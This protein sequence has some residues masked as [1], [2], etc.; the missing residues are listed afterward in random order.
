MNLIRV[1]LVGFGN[2][3]RALV[4]L[5]E[6]KQ[7]QLRSEFGFTTL[8]TG[9][10]TGHHGMAINI[11]GIDIEQ[12]LKISHDGQDISALSAVPDLSSI[13][14]FIN[15]V[16]ADVLFENSPVNHLTGQPAADHLR[17][18]LERGMH[19]ITANKGPVVHAYEE[20]SQLAKRKQ[21]RFLFES[22]VMDGAPI[23][24]LFRGP[25][26][27]VEL[28]GFQGI[29]NSCTNL[30][31][32]MMEGGR[33]FEEA[34]DYGRSIGITETDPSADI[35]GWDAAIKVA[36]LATVLMGR[37]LKPGD[38]QREGI[39]GITP[40]MINE[41]LAEGERW[42]L[43]CS[44]QVTDGVLEARVTPQRVSPLS[45]LYSINGTSSFVQF[46]LDTLPGLGILE[47]NPGPETTA[48]GLLADLINALRDG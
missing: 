13:Q 32:E 44:A 6:S 28:I 17:M 36:A 7:E 4:R 2:V 11:D 3:G 47:S 24:S 48:Y 34:V 39:R 12:A 45:P 37:P 30:L 31:L 20:L 27:A 35:D 19:A 1:A 26:P 15:A 42:K 14:E 18:A 10:A 22:A 23:F 46:Q 8:V 40:A 9:I 38:V 25:L 33:S 29:L 41:A 16:P 43:V 21:R 5:L